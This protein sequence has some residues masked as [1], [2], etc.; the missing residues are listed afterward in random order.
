[1]LISKPRQEEKNLEVS[2]TNET[3]GTPWPLWSDYERPCMES[4]C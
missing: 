1:M 3:R 4:Q 2:E